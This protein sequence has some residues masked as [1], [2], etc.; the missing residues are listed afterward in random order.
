MDAAQCFATLKALAGAEAG[1]I[2]ADTVMD[3]GWRRDAR[4][5]RG[6]AAATTT[7]ASK[8]DAQ[9]RAARARASA[10]LRA[11]V[12]PDLRGDWDTMVALAQTDVVPPPQKEAEDAD[13]AAG[14]VLM[15]LVSTGSLNDDE[16]DPTL[17]PRFARVLGSDGVLDGATKLAT[18][19]PVYLITDFASPEDVKAMRAWAVTA[20][21]AHSRIDEG[22]ASSRSSARTSAS[23]AVP[24]GTL[25]AFDALTE[26]SAALIGGRWNQVEP[27]QVVRYEGGQRFDNH[28]DAGTVRPSGAI[29]VVPPRRVATLLLF[30]TSIDSDDDDHENVPNGATV[31]PRLGIAQRPR[32]GAALLWPNVG[33]DGRPDARTIHRGNPVVGRVKYAV[34]VWIA[35]EDLGGGECVSN[36]LEQLRRKYGVTAP[37]PKRPSPPRPPPPPPPSS[38]SS[39]SS[40]SSES[41]DDDTV[42]PP[43]TDF[44]APD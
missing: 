35:A 34:N 13:A 20:P 44:G 25:P 27:L 33:P 31:F 23:C 12:A 2:V 14:D 41:G 17:P 8:D 15:Q 1:A 10:W 19:P 40:S 42:A 21:F 3:P 39:S 32:A 36:E 22:A 26:R 24:R 30:L 9:M 29:Q 11:K 7:N 4:A 28:H 37:A 38:S 16:A 5:V 18:E 6:C 43:V